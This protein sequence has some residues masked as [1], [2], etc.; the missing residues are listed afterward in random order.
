MASLIKQN[1]WFYLQ[2][3][4]SKRQ[5]QRKRIPLKTRTKRKAKEVRRKLE[6]SFADGSYDPWYDEEQKK[7]ED[8]VRTLGEALQRYLTVKAKEDWRSITA[9]NNEYILGSFCRFCGEGQPVERLNSEAVNSFLN[10]DKFA[11]ETK[12]TYKKRI[13][14]FVRWLLKE[15]YTN[16]S[17]DDVKIFNQDHEQAEGINYLS[18]EEVERLIATIRQKVSEDIKSGYQNKNRNALWLIDLINWQ[19]YSGMRISETLN[20][21]A[22]DINTNTWEV[23]I[24]SEIYSTKSK[25]K[26]VLPIA[27]IDPLVR[28]AEK[29]LREANGETDRLFQ[30]K[31]RRRTSRTFKKYLRLALPEREKITLHSLRHTCCIELLRA[32]V[33]IYTVQRWMRHASIKTTQRYADLLRTDIGKAVAAGFEHIE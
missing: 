27:E 22:R 9:K 3:Y 11:Y 10:Q 20:L 16:N 1:G 21:R 6:D 23:T 31:D 32:G 29:L 25:A 12:R 13:L 19:R 17:F 15:G 8:S 18:I 33:P 4:N 28:I 30:H 5:P 7:E 26:Q 2:F 24:G 14:T